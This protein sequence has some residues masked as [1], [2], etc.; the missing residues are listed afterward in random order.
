MSTVDTMSI[1]H[2]P[3]QLAEIRS[4]IYQLPIVAHLGLEI[5]LTVDGRSHVTIPEVRP[6]HLGGLEGDYLNGGIILSMLDAAVASASLLALGGRR[7]G[8]VEL[9]T[10]I[11]RPVPAEGVVCH[12]WVIQRSQRRV[13]VGARLIDADGTTRVSG[14]GLVCA[15]IG[16]RSA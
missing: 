6:F 12:G 14:V 2:T 8:T 1:E 15:V 4:R 7:C 10:Q 3:E 9:S 13:V 5:D 16:T 11:Q